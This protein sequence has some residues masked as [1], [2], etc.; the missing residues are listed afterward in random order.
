M[1]QLWENKKLGEILKLQRRPVNVTPKGLYKEVGVYCFGKGL[2]HKNARNGTDVGKKP[3]YKIKARDF[4]IQVTFA[5]E[6]AVAIASEDDDGLF[7]S[8]RVLTF[9]VNE[10]ICFPEYL[11]YYFKTPQGLRQL[12]EISSGSAGRNRVLSKRKLPELLIPV[13]NLDQQAN[14]IEKLDKFSN[15][16]TKSNCLRTN[17]L[18]LHGS[19]LQS[20]LSSALKEKHQTLPMSQLFTRD[21][22]QIEIEDGKEYSQLTVALHRRGVRLRGKL[23]GESIKTKKQYLAKAGHF[24]YSRIDARNGAFGFIPEELDGAI[25][26]GDFPCFKINEEMVTPEVIGI[27]LASEDFKNACVAD[28]KGV[29]NRRRLKEGQLLSIK[30]KLPS[31][32]EQQKLTKLVKHLKSSAKLHKQADIETKAIMPA[33]LDKAFKGEL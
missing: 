16:V 24:I 11:L 22:I 13:P 9:E 7:G 3:L 32:R 17:V 6:G 19:L 33:I 18:K 26:T 23:F 15:L 10:D 5:W 29:T 27:I 20:G 4:I 28:S 8:I 2:F 12:G 30:V 1:S 14:I 21:K 31:P 25:V